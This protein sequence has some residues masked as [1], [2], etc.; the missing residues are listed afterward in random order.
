MH[1]YGM[2]P[3]PIWTYQEQFPPAKFVFDEDER[4]GY[5]VDSLISGGNIISGGVVR[6]SVLFSDVHVNANALVEDAVILPN[7]RIGKDARL[8]RVV[9]DRG[10]IIPEGLVAGMDPIQDRERFYVS[11]NGITLIT[12]EMLNQRNYHPG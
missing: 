1:K 2:N 12:A 8:K 10:C 9:V 3:W 5:A 6:R 4:R 11:E 7:V